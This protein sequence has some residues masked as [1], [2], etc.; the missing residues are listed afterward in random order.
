MDLRRPL[1]DVSNKATDE[2]MAQ[3]K[4]KRT[5]DAGLENVDPNG[6]ARQ[7]RRERNAAM[8]EEEKEKR[9][10]RARENYHR[11]KSKSIVNP[12]LGKTNVDHNEPVLDSGKSIGPIT[13]D[14]PMTFR[15][16]GVTTTSS[17][18]VLMDSGAI[19]GSPCVRGLSMSA[20]SKKRAVRKY[21]DLPE[22]EKRHAKHRMRS[23]RSIVSG[24]WIGNG[25]A[26]SQQK[27]GRQKLQ[28][29][30]KIGYRGE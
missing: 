19:T 26:D 18:V 22:E 6:R 17:G 11:N 30:W 8:T 5:G 20:S 16:S 14:T 2:T 1:G 4:R 3:T 28:N 12:L 21:A 10:G 25:I 27:K 7:R 29:L 15:V 9:R 24:R 13:C 23:R